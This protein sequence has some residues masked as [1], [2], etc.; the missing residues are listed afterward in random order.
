MPCS[1]AAR[2][3]RVEVVDR[4]RAPGG[5]RRGRRLASPIAHGLPGSPGPAMSVLLRALAVRVAD[6]VDRRQVEDV[7]AELGELR[8]APRRPRSRPRSAGTARTRRRSARARARPRASSGSA[9]RRLVAVGVALGGAG[10]SGRA[11]RRARRSARRRRA[12]ASAAR[13]LRVGALGALAAA[14]EQQRALA[15]ARPSGRSGRRRPCARP[16]RARRR[17]GRSTPRSCTPA[18]GSVDGEAPAQRSPSRCASMRRSGASCQRP[19]PGAAVAHDGA[20]HLVAVAED[21]GRHVTVSPTQR[22]AG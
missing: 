9:G 5:S 19:S 6:R 3:E 2:D 18:P 15:T 16:R 20:Q 17:T 12:R 13:A 10:S 21:V 22:L 14:L 7:E 4:A 8:D 1:R 11:R